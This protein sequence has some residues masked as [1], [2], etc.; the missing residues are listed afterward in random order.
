VGTLATLMVAL[1][2]E[3]GPYTEGLVKSKEATKAFAES[4]K[5][6]LGQ[7]ADSHSKLGS[8]AGLA[9]KAVVASVAS[10]GIAVIAAGAASMKLASEFDD[11]MRQVQTQGGVTAEVMESMKAGVIA[12]SARYGIAATDLAKAMMPIAAEG[13]S[14]AQGIQVLSTA[15]AGAKGYNSDLMTTTLALTTAMKDYNFSAKDSWH[16]MD[17]LGKATASGRTN[18]QDLAGSIATVLP[19]ASSLKISFEGVMGAVTQMTSQGVPAN[20]ATQELRFSLMALEKPSAAATKALGEVHLKTDD[21]VKSLKSGPEGLINTLGTVQQAVAKKFPEG[22]AEYIR[23]LSAIMGGVKGLQ[24]ML[25]LTGAHL[26]DTIKSTKGLADASKDGG[27]TMEAWGA[28]QEETGVKMDQLR[29]TVKGVAIT[30][31][32]RLLPIFGIAIDWFKDK[33]PAAVGAATK[34]Y[35]DHKAQLALIASVIGTGLVIAFHVLTTVL[36]TVTDHWK[37]IAPFIVAAVVALVAFKT[38]MAVQAL[39]QGVSMAMFMLQAGMAGAAV[40]EV[41]ASTASY[42][43]GVAIDFMLGPMGLVVLAVA[44]VIAVGILLVTHWD[45]VKKAAGNVWHAVLGAITTVWDWVK[46]NWPML[47]AIL[48]APFTGGLSLIVL[49]VVSHFSQIKSFIGGAISG[50]GGFFKSLPG[51]AGDAIEAVVGFF[52]S[53]PERAIFALGFLIGFWAKF[54]IE[55][56]GRA[57]TALKTSASALKDG[58]V[59]VVTTLWSGLTTGFWIVIG[60][61]H[62]LPGHAWDALKAGASTVLSVGGWLISTMWSGM[63]A[64]AGAVWSWVTTIPGYLLSLIK[65]LGGDLVSFGKFIVSKIVEGIKAAPGAVWDA[66]KGLAG[67]LGGALGSIAGAISGGA[68]SLAGG[69]QSGF[70]KQAGGPIPLTGMYLLHAGEHVLNRQQT[71]AMNANSSGVSRA[72]VG[73][74]SMQP[75]TGGGTTVTNNI[76]VQGTNLSPQ[77]ISR[78]LAWVM[79]RLPLRR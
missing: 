9:G 68:G 23:A 65:G 64:A 29:E 69:V 16:V 78:E 50:I 33:I 35:D 22:S 53:L 44:A 13:F 59:W 15:A 47:V 28:V 66:I 25:A 72:G 39:I 11:A 63:T 24:P 38:A 27:Y 79:K 46:N 70:S 2:L 17:V 43:L 71:A 19:L 21:L 42:A 76:T 14:G 10:V 5:T 1:G 49:L 57:F 45:I 4:S 7:V 56:P 34:A 18:F 51:Y 75:Q 41:G 55:M 48:L 31:G 67:G 54:W 40:A 32:E 6:S 73:I 61:F 20:L 62:D 26:Q 12:T 52:F 77:D 30:V 3:T 74:A 58:G 60:F 36:G 37:I 8:I